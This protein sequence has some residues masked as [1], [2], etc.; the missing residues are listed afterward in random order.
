MD[1]VIHEMRLKRL[2]HLM[3]GTPMRHSDEIAGSNGSR[4]ECLASCMVGE[5][6]VKP[7]GPDPAGICWCAGS[8]GHRA[9]SSRIV[10]VI[11]EAATDSVA[12]LAWP[13]QP[14]A[15]ICAFPDAAACGSAGRR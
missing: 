1:N 12:A 3:I 8:V 14:R 2:W 6:A 9:D 7:A 4:V 15:L 11:R 13:V 10:P 5:E